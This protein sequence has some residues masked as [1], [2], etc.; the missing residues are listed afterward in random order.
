M[1]YS[2]NNE[3]KESSSYIEKFSGTNK[4]GVKIRGLYKEYGSQPVVDGI[5]LDLY[6]GQI[7]CLLG[8]NGNQ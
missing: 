5:S 7:F 6:E 8:H 3:N 1:D 2:I 4:V